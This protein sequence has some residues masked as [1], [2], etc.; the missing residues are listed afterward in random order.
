MAVSALA[1]LAFSGEVVV[2]ASPVDAGITVWDLETGAER[3]HLRS[4]ASPRHGLAAV[5]LQFVAASQVQ[6]SSSAASGAIFYWQWNKP[7][8]EIRSFP[9]EHIGPI[10]CNT[11]GTYIVGGGSSG[12]IYLWEVPSGQLLK[13]WPAH[14]K[15]LTCLVFS[16]DE[17]LLISGAEDGFVRAWPLLIALDEDAALQAETQFQPLHNFS[18]HNLPVKDIV[19]GYGGCNAIIVSSS[20]DFTYKTDLELGFGN[21]S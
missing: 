4:C 6:K 16:D 3:L 21:S 7:Q 12:R 13:V 2:V 1:K 15:A 8:A 18:A 10:A 20:S 9:V 5:G 19:C 14:Y 17:S 11:D